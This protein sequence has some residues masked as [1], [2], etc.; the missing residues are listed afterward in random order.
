MVTLHALGPRSWQP[1]P[2]ALDFVPECLLALILDDKGDAAVV[3]LIMGSVLL[4]ATLGRVFKVL[5]LLPA[6]AIILAVVVARSAYLGHD[7]LHLILE[8][9]ALS[10]SVQIGYGLTCLS[11]VSNTRSIRNTWFRVSAR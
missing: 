4:G 7:V 6:S 11:G 9:A 10:T 3:I 8:Y 5:V 2:I 1:D